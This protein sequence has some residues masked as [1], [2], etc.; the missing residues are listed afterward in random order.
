MDF[1]LSP[2]IESYRTRIRA[3][4]E[5]HVMPLELDPANYDEG[6]NIKDSV[7]GPVREKAKAE[8]LWALQMPKERGG[9]G[10]SITGMAASMALPSALECKARESP[11]G[12]A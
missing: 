12:E 9:Q 11:G 8:G 4:V 6:E 2:E 1:S 10:L 7:L 5:T 3:F